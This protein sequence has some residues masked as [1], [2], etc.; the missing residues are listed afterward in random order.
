[1][2]K[3]LALLLLVPLLYGT[4]TAKVYGESY[5]KKG[6]TIE[7]KDTIEPY[8]RGGFRSPR[9][10]YNPGAGAPRRTT[11]DNAARPA[12]PRTTPAP[13]TGFGGF[14]GGMFGGLAMG[15]IL[16]SLFN[17]FAGFS[18]GAP[19]LSLI[20]FALWAIV[21]FAVIRMFRRRRES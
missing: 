8:R 2:R 11:P 4:P 12:P 18:L 16:G 1:M 21:I 14:F 3:I 17:P 10:G 13:R 15:A 20:S 5:D 6:E 7:R 9:Q 19:M